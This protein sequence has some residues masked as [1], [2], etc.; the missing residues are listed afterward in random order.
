MSGLEGIGRDLMA[1]AFRGDQP[2][3][4]I[5]A[6]WDRTGKAEQE[7]FQLL[8][9]G[10]MMRIRDPKAHDDV[11]QGDP[12]RALEYLAFASLLMRRLDDATATRN[13]S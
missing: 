3:I 1:R 13:E 11:Q 12:Q 2:P 5:A 10:A 4:R 9:M 7:G 6:R 8:F